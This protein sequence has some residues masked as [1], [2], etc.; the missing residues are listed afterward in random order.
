MLSGRDGG[1]AHLPPLSLRGDGLWLID[2]A[3]EAMWS[4]INVET[5]DGAGSSAEATR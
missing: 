5:R 1:V 4:Y 2:D 3:D